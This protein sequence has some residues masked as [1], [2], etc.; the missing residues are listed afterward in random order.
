MLVVVIVLFLSDARPI[1]V[2]GQLP[3]LF[4]MIALVCGVAFLVALGWHMTNLARLTLSLSRCIEPIRLRRGMS[5]W[6][7]PQSLQEPVQTPFNLSM[8]AD[9]VKALGAQTLQEW[10]GETTRII[11]GQ[12]ICPPTKTVFKA[13]QQRLVAEL[14]LLVVAIRFSAWCAMAAP[15]AVLMAMSVYPPIYERWLRTTSIA[16][17]LIG[18]VCTVIVVLRL[19]KDAMLGPMFTRDGD[20]LTFG[21]SLRALWPK[22]LAMG[23]VLVPLV[24]PDVVD[25]INTLVR[26]INSLG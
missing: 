13:W 6:P 26:S 2:D 12:R 25:W 9:D 8:E 10:I 24:L 14:K 21:G 17:L 1:S 4:A 7:S 16:M 5:A 20:S 23:A 11:A 18:F 3:W 19:E 22:F 15:L